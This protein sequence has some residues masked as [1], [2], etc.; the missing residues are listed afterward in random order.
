MKS[1]KYWTPEDFEIATHSFRLSERVNRTYSKSGTDNTGL[2]EY[3]YNELGFRGDSPTKSGF[4]VMSIG[5]SITEGVGVNN[6]DTWSDQ[7]SN[8]IPNG[9]NLNFGTGGR[10]N[11]FITRC[12]L[13]YY[14]LIRPDLVLI[15]YTESHRREYFTGDG[16]VEPYHVNKWGY[17]DETEEGVKNHE[18]LLE[19]SNKEYN[20]QNWYKNHLLIKYFLESKGCNW[21]WN[22]WFATKGY[23]DDLRFD[24]DFH[25]F[26][27]YGVDGK[28]PGINTH[29]TY[30]SKLH[31]H[32]KQHFPY[33]LP[34]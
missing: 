17:F 20:F 11:D 23:Q 26:I 21:L 1:L 24:G 9:V 3:S 14:D 32:I 22:G 34:S 27:D 2:C 25:P 5:C 15:M 19:L 4:K 12:L 7:F 33:Y 30:A 13:S 6:E 8:Y 29:K 18:S 16:G 10:S 28:H 31:S